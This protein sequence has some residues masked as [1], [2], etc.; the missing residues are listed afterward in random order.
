[1]KTLILASTSPRRKEILEKSGLDFVTE[2]SDFEEDMSLDLTPADLVKQL[3]LGKAKAVADK[4]RDA[5][6]IGS[7][8]IISFNNKIL[9]KPHTAEWAKEMLTELRG[10]QHSVWTGYSI[11]DTDSGKSVSKS[12]EARVFFKHLSSQEIDDY[13]ETGEPID[14]AGAYAIQGIGKSLIDHIEGDFYTIMGLPLQNVLEDLK[15][16]G[17]AVRN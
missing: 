9:G 4:H 14:K 5:V 8:T 11:I 16:F 3:S 7:D 17:F 1:M 2:A 10:Q 15:Q 6:V 13:I 12:V